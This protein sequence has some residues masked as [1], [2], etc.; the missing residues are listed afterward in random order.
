VQLTD[1]RL[2]FGSNFFPGGIF[3]V[4]TSTNRKESSDVLGK[5]EKNQ[6]T[7]GVMLGVSENGCFFPKSSILIEIS[8][9]NHPF[10]GTPIF[11]NTLL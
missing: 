1:N 4:P 2:V 9:I 6:Q 10:W 7:S 5:L 11:G 3:I 8:S